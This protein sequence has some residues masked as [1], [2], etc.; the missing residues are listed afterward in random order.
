[1][2]NLK[3]LVVCL[4]LFLLGCGSP[5][6]LANSNNE[7]NNVN[8]SN[9]TP[10]CGDGILDPGESCD[11]G[12][13]N[14][15]SLPDACRTDCRTAYCGDSVLDSG[16]ECDGD[17]LNNKVCTDFSAT[18]G[19]LSCNE[20][21]FDM[22]QC[23]TCGDGEAEGELGDLHYEMCDGSDLRGEDCVS[24]GQAQ[25]VLRC[26]SNC[27]WDIS[28][29]VGGGAVC[30]DGVVDA[31]EECDDGNNNV[32]DACLS[33]PMGTCLFAS[34]GDGY[35]QAGVESCDD[36]NGDNTDG[37]PDG[38]GGTCE[39]A[40]CGDGHVQVGAENCEPSL[41]PTCNH[42]CTNYCGDGATR[43]PERCDDNISCSSDCQRYCGDGV[44]DTDL[45]EVCDVMGSGVGSDPYTG[46]PPG[47]ATSYGGIWQD[48]LANCQPSVCGDGICNEW[49]LGMVGEPFTCPQDCP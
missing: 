5:Y 2:K 31:G 41:D 3:T 6:Y 35:L 7:N 47:E 12:S 26:N 42:N 34:C 11:D 13:A 49:T 43:S 19:V 39:A 29:C 17:N 44:V 18:M 30:G 24:I 15:D 25:G 8:N 28:G 46:G 22:S 10:V 16:E 32:T 20:C 48:C 27:G 36:G 21:V 38:V 9:H 23:S 45:G 14:S 4:P 1:M 40:S 33:G 37:C